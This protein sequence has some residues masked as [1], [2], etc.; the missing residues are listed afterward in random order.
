MYV[1]VRSDFDAS[2]RMVQGAHALTKYVQENPNTAQVWNNEY[3]IFL[4][5]F[6]EINLKEIHSNL[7]ANGF[8][9]A[10]FNEPDQNFQ[11]TAL[12]VY[13]DGSGHVAKIL[14]GLQL[15]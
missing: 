5:T 8:T 10:A 6:L 9:V 12:A 3:L 2:Y 1:V 13:E 4:R 11:M 7:V 15:A 14:K